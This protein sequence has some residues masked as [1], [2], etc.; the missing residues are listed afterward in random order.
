[1]EAELRIVEV[2][3]RRELPQHARFKQAFVLR[4]GL[5]LH[6]ERR[7][8]AFVVVEELHLALQVVFLLVKHD[9]FEAA[10]SDGN[11]VQFAVWI[12]LQYLLDNYG[13]AGV[14]DAFVLR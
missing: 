11:N 1:M 7:R 14:D 9:H 5:V 13:A 4:Q 12:G 6:F 2:G 10:A 8:A 3:L